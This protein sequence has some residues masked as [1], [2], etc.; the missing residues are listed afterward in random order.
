MACR[1][2]FLFVPPLMSSVSNTVEDF[3]L[4]PLPQIIQNKAVSLFLDIYSV[5]RIF[6]FLQNKTNKDCQWCM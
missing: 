2:I 3:S 1:F 5:P 4:N 6:H